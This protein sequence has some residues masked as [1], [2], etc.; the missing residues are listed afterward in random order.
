M[1]KRLVVVRVSGGSEG[2][3]QGGL[4]VR[5]EYEEPSQR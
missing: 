5:G 4:A 3:R 2:D 1:E